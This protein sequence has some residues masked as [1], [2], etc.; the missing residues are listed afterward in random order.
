MTT[1]TVS[2]ELLDELLSGVENANDLPGDQGLMRKIKVRLMERML[3]AGL[4]EHPDMRAT[5]PIRTTFA[6]LRHSTLSYW[7]R[8]FIIDLRYATPLSL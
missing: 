2:K 1:M 6:Q 3:G 8:S 7:K 4:T 5:R